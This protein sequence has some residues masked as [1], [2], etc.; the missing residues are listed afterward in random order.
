M[1]PFLDCPHS[2][3]AL[4]PC[5]EIRSHCCVLVPATG[6]AHGGQQG[7]RLVR[8]NGP[9][10]ASGGA[11]SLSRQP[12]AFPPKAVRGLGHDRWKQE[13][14]GWN[15]LTPNWSLKHGFLHA[16]QHRP[17]T[18]VIE[19][20]QSPPPAG[21]AAHQAPSRLPAVHPNRKITCPQP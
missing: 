3:Q 12:Q 16:C 19:N 14:N 11:Q 4:Q 18:P 15:D 13:N 17:H 8:E 7:N 1:A 21:V 2:F 9:P 20:Q 5:N 6:F 10:A